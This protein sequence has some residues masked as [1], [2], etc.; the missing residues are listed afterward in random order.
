MCSSNG[1]HCVRRWFIIEKNAAT[2]VDL[3][4]DKAGRKHRPGG[5]GFGWPVVRT[6]ITRHDALNHPTVDQDDRIIVPSASIENTI[7]RDCRL[8]SSGVFGGF[9]T[10]CLASS[11]A[12]W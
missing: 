4:V 12:G 3:K 8:A 10:H 6:L 7:S 2:T 9:H 5:H 11:M 1:A